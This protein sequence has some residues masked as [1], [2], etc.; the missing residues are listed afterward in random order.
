MLSFA[1]AAEYCFFFL[2]RKSSAT[3]SAD[4]HRL[5]CLVH[6]IVIIIII[7][8]S[9][10]WFCHCQQI[11]R[12][13]RGSGVRRCHGDFHCAS[14]ICKNTYY[15]KTSYIDTINYYN[16]QCTNIIWTFFS[17][18][19]IEISLIYAM[20]PWIV[21]VFYFQFLCSSVRSPMCHSVVPVS[22]ITNS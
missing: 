18:L 14:F 5:M 15:V 9:I 11:R 17:Q 20:E 21:I 10:R 16:F 2:L 1:S 13:R 22:N 19:W 4:N 7:M 8:I 12:K 6:L 3:T